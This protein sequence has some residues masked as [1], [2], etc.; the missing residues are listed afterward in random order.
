MFNIGD[1]VSPNTNCYIFNEFPYTQLM[2]RVGR[3]VEIHVTHELPITIEWKQG[4]PKLRIN[5]SP[6]EL[7]KVEEESIL[8]ES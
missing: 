6:H 8:W 4:E 3:V 5:H 1:R 7:I 2:G